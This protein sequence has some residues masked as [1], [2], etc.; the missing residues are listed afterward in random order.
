MRQ[1]HSHK[2]FLPLSVFF[3]AGHAHPPHR[4]VLDVVVKPSSGLSSPHQRQLEQL[5][6][7]CCKAVLRTKVHP[8]TAISITLQVENDGG[9]VGDKFLRGSLL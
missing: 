3:F 2:K 5:I 8:H 1:I 4:A 7:G 6:L 9:A